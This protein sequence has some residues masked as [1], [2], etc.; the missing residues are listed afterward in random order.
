MAGRLFWFAVGVGCTAYIVIKGREYQQRL[1]PQGLT[2]QV[3]KGA[4]TLAGR[5]GEFIDTFTE[6]TAAREAELRAELGM[7]K[8]A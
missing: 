2:Q 7:E 5:V 8:H 4:S 6:A 3:S 1:S